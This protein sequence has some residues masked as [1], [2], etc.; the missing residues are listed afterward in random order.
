LP[1]YSSS[2]DPT[3]HHHHQ[4]THRSQS[5]EEKFTIL[6]W[7][8]NNVN[9]LATLTALIIALAAEANGIGNGIR[10]H[11]MQ[12][13]AIA[14]Y[15]YLAFAWQSS[16]L[17][18]QKIKNTPAPWILGVVV[19]C[20]ILTAFPP[21]RAYHADAMLRP[22]AIAELYRML[23]CFGI[24]LGSAFLLKAEELR[25]VAIG[26]LIVVSAVAL[27]ATTLIGNEGSNDDALTGIWG[28]HEQIGSYIAIAFPVALALA[29]N[30]TDSKIISYICDGLAVILGCALIV[31][32]TRSA[33]IGEA[34]GLLVLLAASIR[35]ASIKITK[36]TKF[37]LVGAPLVLLIGFAALATSDQVSEQL[38]SR[39]GTF[40]N[41]TD[42]ASLKDR[43]HRWDCACRMTYQRPIIGW[44]LGSFP[45]IQ[46]HWTRTGQTPAEVIDHGAEHCNIA[47]NFWVQWASE[48][49][50]IGLALY[51]AM[52][53]AFIINGL[54]NLRNIDGNFRRSLS[55][56]CI[57]AVATSAIDM[58]G[59]PSYTYPGVSSV[60][61]LWMG[62][63]TSAA[64]FRYA[65]TVIGDK[66]N[67]LAPWKVITI[68]ILVGVIS[69]VVV[70]VVGWHQPPVRG[71]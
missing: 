71:L 14:Y 68:A 1:E 2:T 54:A 66:P 39:I 52:I 43:I 56:G 59:A 25:T 13:D 55:I 62:I 53:V 17:S 31:S 30:P 12:F 29:I 47:H 10:F 60:P 70:Y 11:L 23:L 27:Y 32:R 4:H 37:L 5:K 8:S 6:S 24:F 26:L 22:F 20:V 41:V 34:A 9:A 36:A 40:N 18:W 51:V 38:L 3:P 16:G 21:S 61:F 35:F 19:W 65:Q 69:A 57:A 46:Y 7:M 64:R 45:V 33:W 42:D 48:T 15:L 63:V 50:L 44:G 28:N 49:G 67:P 58:F